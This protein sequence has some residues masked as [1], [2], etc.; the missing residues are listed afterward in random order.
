M[1]Y[2]NALRALASPNYRLFFFGQG[3][4]LLGNWMTFTAS[5]WLVYELT[6]DPF[7]VGLLAF[8]SQIPV[9][10]LAPLA[11]VLGDRFSRQRL[12]WWLNIGCAAE[13]AALAGLVLTDQITVGWLFTL[14]GFRGVINAIEFPTRQS[15]VVDLVERRADVPNAIALNSS[16]FNVA[17]LIGPSL[18]GL[19]IATGGPGL[20]Y[21]IDAVS[22]SAILTSLLAMRIKPHQRTARRKHPLTEFRE[23]LAYARAAAPLR[24]SLLMVPVIALAGFAA[25]TLAPV[26]ARD[27]FEADSVALGNMLSAVGLGALVSAIMLAMR[28]SPEGLARWVALGAFSI[29]AGQL[30]FALSPS[31]TP[32]LVCLMF[33][34]FGTVL[35]MAGNNTLIQSY[36][37]DDKRSRV[38]GLFAM[39]Q[40][41]FPV[42]ALLA[43]ALAAAA[44]P[45]IAVAVAAVVTALAGV[46]FIR[47]SRAFSGLQ[48]RPPHRPAPLPSDSLT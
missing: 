22:F 30:G 43:G 40:G 48:P 47:A 39:G 35:C 44:G 23:G 15:F 4:S 1:P 45:R 19:I 21:L 32:A 12:M 27:I 37:A 11:G 14:V 8:V 7:K 17:R 25:G 38:M 41:M 24:P 28:P 10:V 6:R 18:A 33:T 5:S 34:G 13:A 3:I 36:V 9:L 29:A 31:L 42:G 20:C 2:P 16:L 26:F 46:A